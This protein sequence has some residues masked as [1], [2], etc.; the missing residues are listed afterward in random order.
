MRKVSLADQPCPVA[1]SLDAVGEWWTLMLVRD[2][3]RGARRFEEFRAIGIADNVLAA[4]L[5]RLVDLGIFE[6]RLYQEHPE[7]YEYLL[8]AKG[9]DL[10]TV[11]GALA[12][13]GVRWTEGPDLT[14]MKG[15]RHDACGHIVTMK[16]YCEAC[17]RTVDVS[18]VR[19]PHL[20]GRSPG[21]SEAKVLS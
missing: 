16:A 12:A 8:T 15:I 3:F 1:R 21:P 9:S 5:R 6:R 13:W 4:R 7:R 10:L 17:D 2:A 20:I 11:V 19:V 18:E 14:G